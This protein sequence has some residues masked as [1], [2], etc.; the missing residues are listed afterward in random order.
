VWIEPRKMVAT[1]A[2]GRYSVRSSASRRAAG[3][4]Q[5]A[6]HEGDDEGADEEGLTEDPA[7]SSTPVVE[8]QREVAQLA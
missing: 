8:R 4:G 3:G 6:A 1:E 2:R 5:P 7:G